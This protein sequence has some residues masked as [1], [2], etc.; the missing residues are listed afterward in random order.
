MCAQLT[1]LH[2]PDTN[3]T[4]QFPAVN[5]EGANGNANHHHHQQRQPASDTKPRWSAP[6]YSSQSK[7]QFLRVSLSVAMALLLVTK[8]YAEL[9]FGTLCSVTACG[10][11]SAG[12]APTGPSRHVLRCRN[13][14]SQATSINMLFSTMKQTH[15]VLSSK[16]LKG[17]IQG[18]I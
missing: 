18:I 10:L 15:Y 9:E 8:C 13:R 3:L 7:C 1:S 6:V 17:G 5:V 11:L 16:L 2:A 4:H 14:R 12:A